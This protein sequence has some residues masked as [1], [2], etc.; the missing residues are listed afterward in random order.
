MDLVGGGMDLVDGGV[1]LVGYC[2]HAAAASAVGAV[3]RADP[4]GMSSDGM[5]SSADWL[6]VDCGLPADRIYLSAEL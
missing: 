5:K 6:R 4:F 1:D 2:A 3:S